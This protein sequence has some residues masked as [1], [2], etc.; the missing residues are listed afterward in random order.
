VRVL[1]TLCL[2]LMLVPLRSRRIGT[3]Q[4]VELAVFFSRV[5]HL[6]SRESLI[7]LPLER[8]G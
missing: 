2:N 6:S 3:T 1:L 4:I 5:F 7:V 8:S